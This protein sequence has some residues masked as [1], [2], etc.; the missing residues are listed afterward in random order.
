MEILALPQ[1][2]PL[3]SPTAALGRTF[4]LAQVDMDPL[5]AAVGSRGMVLLV[6]LVLSVVCW[7]VIG[8]RAWALYNLRKE[9]KSFRDEFTKFNDL[10]DAAE[11]LGRK[12]LAL[13]HV[14]LM[15]A[16]M[17]EMHA[18]ESRGALR[19]RDV[20]ALERSMRRVA[21]PL[22]DEL[23]SGLSLLGT[24]ASSAPFIGLFGTVWGIMGAFGGLADSGSILQS[25]APHIAQALVATAVGLLAAIP[26][27]MAYNFLGRN[28]RK[29][30]TDLDGFGLEILNMVRRQDLRPEEVGPAAAPAV[31]ASRPVEVRAAA[32]V[33]A[34]RTVASKSP[35]LAGNSL[36]AT[37]IP[38]PFPA[39]EGP[40]PAGSTPSKEG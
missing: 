34:V 12:Y 7:V 40:A 19:E 26:A 22:V 23:E 33:V 9:I 30:V 35:P 21:E 16:V 15:A 29:M 32:P 24:V 11:A 18:L 36:S 20:D 17:K 31:G 3:F 4:H 5:A 38:P 14:R 1:L 25:V 6:L 10:R 27:S 13:P 2:L 39:G 8:S 28:V 37:S